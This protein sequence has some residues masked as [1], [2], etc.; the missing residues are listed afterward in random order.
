MLVGLAKRALCVRRKANSWI[1]FRVISQLCFFMGT[2]AMPG[3][4]FYCRC[5]EAS[6]TKRA[7]H[8]GCLSIL[9]AIGI[10]PGRAG[11]FWSLSWGGPGEGPLSAG[12]ALP[13]CLPCW[14]VDYT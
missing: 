10:V 11:A 9:D 6:S 1:H 4:T 5:L 8:Q 13:L 14:S 2:L 7:R 12:V 3:E